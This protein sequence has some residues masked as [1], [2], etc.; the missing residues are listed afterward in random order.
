MSPRWSAF[1]GRKTNSV[2]DREQIEL[3]YAR[4]PHLSL[5]QRA[6]LVVLLKDELERAERVVAAARD[7]AMTHHG[8]MQMLVTSGGNERIPREKLERLRK[9][10]DEW[11]QAVSSQ[12]P[13]T[14]FVPVESR[15]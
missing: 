12:S 13:R 8:P 2:T 3:L 5:T 4:W 14:P 10:L 1:V 6:Q 9:A 11:D 7:V 15:P